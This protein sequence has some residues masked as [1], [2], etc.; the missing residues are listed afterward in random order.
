MHSTIL[1]V[2]RKCW[3]RRESLFETG[4]VSVGWLF[5]DTLRDKPL[6]HYQTFNQ[7][8]YEGENVTMACKFYSS[9]PP[10]MQWLKHYS[11]NDSDDKESLYEN[12]YAVKVSASVPV[13]LLEK[14]FSGLL[15]MGWIILL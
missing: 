14:S 10:L 13:W 15:W 5:A 12:Y 6:L 7:T 9:S 1:D 2:T 4:S 8:V 11:L 3:N